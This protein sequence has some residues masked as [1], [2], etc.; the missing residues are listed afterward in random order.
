M[1]GWEWDQLFQFDGI[2]TDMGDSDLGPGPGL[3]EWDDLYDGK[4]PPLGTHASNP[5]SPKHETSTDAWNTAFEEAIQLS[6]EEVDEIEEACALASDSGSEPS[7]T[8]SSG[9]G[10]RLTLWWSQIFLK[11]AQGLGLSWPGVIP[12]PL[13]VVSGCTGCSAEAAAL[14]ARLKCWKGVET[15]WAL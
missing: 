13:Y 14:K 10:W 7:S 1:A 12:K 2:A 11:A 8:C 4:P 5:S 3:N 6:Q 9:S 15:L